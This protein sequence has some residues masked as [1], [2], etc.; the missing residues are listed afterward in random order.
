MCAHARTET[1]ERNSA[2]HGEGE[3]ERRSDCAGDRA[4]RQRGRRP[5]HEDGTA[6]RQ[7]DSTETDRHRPDDGWRRAGI[8]MRAGCAMAASGFARARNPGSMMMKNLPAFCVGGAAY[9]AARFT[10][11]FGVSNRASNCASRSDNST[12]DGQWGHTFRFLQMV[13]AATA[14]R[15]ESSSHLVCRFPI[16]PATSPNYGGWAW[17]KLSA[18]G[19]AGGCEHLGNE[20]RAAGLR[21]DVRGSAGRAGGASAAGQL[22]SGIPDG[23]PGGLRGTALRQGEDR[24]CGGDDFGAG[25]CEEMPPAAGL[26]ASREGEMEGLDHSERGAEPYPAFA[27]ATTGAFGGDHPE[28]LGYRP[29][30]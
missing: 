13:F 5:P 8:L 6:G 23:H 30:T 12:L 28:P 16:P 17:G 18:A 25:G 21:H 20:V 19:G 26:R 10:P 11:M 27:R 4:R 24:R 3:P 22:D 7:G 1:R 14:E 15:T 2:G 29:E 9:R